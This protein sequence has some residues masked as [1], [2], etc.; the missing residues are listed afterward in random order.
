MTLDSIG[1]VWRVGPKREQ[2]HPKLE[3][4]WMKRYQELIQY[5]FTHG[6]YWVP[7]DRKDKKNPL[8]PLAKWAVHQRQLFKQGIL[9]E[10]RKKLL[11]DIDFAWDAS[12]KLESQWNACLK[13]LKEIL[14]QENSCLEPGDMYPKSTLRTSLYGWVKSQQRSYAKGS[15]P[16]KRK[17]LLDDIGFP[18]RESS[19]ES[20]E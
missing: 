7:N 12:E 18:W 17:A 3:E 2:Y 13:E 19:E 5:K 15:I 20:V 14:A 9:R 11:F 8:N 6:D 4:R 16:P 1:F 10:D